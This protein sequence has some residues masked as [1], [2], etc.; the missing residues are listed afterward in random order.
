MLRSLAYS[1]AFI[2]A[3]GGV[4]WLAAHHLV[5]EQ[6]HAQRV[7]EELDALRNDMDELRLRV[8]APPSPPPPPTRP[9]EPDP[10]KVYAVP[11]GDAAVRGPADALVTVVAFTDYQCPFCGRAEATLTSLR[12]RFPQEVRVVVQH[13]PLAFHKA[14]FD[15]AVAAE[16]AGEQGLFWPLHDRLFARQ[17]ELSGS[18]TPA[19]IADGVE[20][21]QWSAFERCVAGEGARARVTEDQR[22]AER[23]GVR[24]TPS[25]FINGRILVGAQPLE[26]FVEVVERELATARQSGIERAEYYRRAVLEKGLPGV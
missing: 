2:A 23:F 19:G 11:V 3:L 26:R 1:L 22:L 8:D 21:L 14:A 13:Q 16:C 15:A 7:Q 18:V 9:G 4:S 20:G 17:R 10:A 24:G 5:R 25:F 6:A 12:E